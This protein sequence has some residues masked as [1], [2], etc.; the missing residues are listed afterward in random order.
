MLKLISAF[1]ATSY[2]FSVTFIAFL[3]AFAF[4]KPFLRQ[5]FANSLRKYLGLFE[6]L[7][8]GVAESSLHLIV[9]K[10]IYIKFVNL[11][12]GFSKYRIQI[13][14]PSFQLTLVE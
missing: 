13:I 4:D 11:F 3:T 5:L 2:I 10:L 1:V 9:I 6:V 8:S 7:S 14:P 12:G